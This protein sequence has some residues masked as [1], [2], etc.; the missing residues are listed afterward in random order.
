MKVVQDGVVA[1][2][3]SRGWGV[4]TRLVVGILVLAGVIL[5]GRQFADLV[6]A[7][8]RWVGDLGPLGPLA[9]IAGY[10]VAAVAFVPGALLTVAAGAVFGVAAGT[11]YV[12]VG[13]TLGSAAAFLVSR[14][15]A[16]GAF[17]RR[18]SDNPRFEAIDHAIALEG[19]KVVFLLRLS[20]VIPFTLLNY[21]LGLTRVTF[22]D[23]MIASI[24]MLPGTLLY[25]YAGKVAGDLAALAAGQSP[26][27]GAGSVVVLALGFLATVGVTVLVTRL[28]RRAL[29]ESAGESR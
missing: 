17:E 18:L 12:L 4:R 29:S 1:G 26:P 24:G 6:P 25:T 9:F 7:F 28:A 5:G 21:A 15:L 23:F 19:R 16:R 11:A 10:V 3:G 2:P 27:R 13:A 14:H 20:P 22:A 8:V